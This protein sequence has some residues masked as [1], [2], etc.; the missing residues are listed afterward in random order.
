MVILDFHF[1]FQLLD[2]SMDVSSLEALHA[3]QN[4]LEK[5]KVM[6]LLCCF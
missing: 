1:D 5:I 4:S 6:P 2:L 3:V